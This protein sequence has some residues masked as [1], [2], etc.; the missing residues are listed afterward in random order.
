MTNSTELGF[1]HNFV[2]PKEGAG[3]VLFLLHGTG[4]TEN[5]LIPLGR[6]INKSAAILSPRGKV[7][8][9]GA[10]RF[11]R[12]LAEGVFD[13]D[14]LKFQTGELSDFIEK[15]SDFYK[16]GLQSVVAIGYSNGANMAASLLL[17]RPKVVSSAILFRP[18]VPL[19]PEIL[20]DLSTKNIF[21]SGGLYDPIVP[22][23]ETERLVDLFK[24]C[25]SNIFI[26]WENS[27][28]ELRT[29]EITVA[30]NWLS[31]LLK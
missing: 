11:F 28:H 21:V 8:E 19:V 4:G 14:D 1:I 26:N 15:A 24:K 29:E 17:L 18:M 23:V 27:G 30:R 31:N 16:F 5:D 13:I 20:P 2:E 9:N 3:M 7:L 10:P 22:K 25:G 12:R 6:E